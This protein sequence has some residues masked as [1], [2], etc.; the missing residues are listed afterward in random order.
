MQFEPPSDVSDLDILTVIVSIVQCG[1]AFPPAAEGHQERTPGVLPRRNLP[2]LL[3]SEAWPGENGSWPHQQTLREDWP[4]PSI[5]QVQQTS[6]RKLSEPRLETAGLTTAS[7]RGKARQWIDHE[8]HKN[9]K[10]GRRP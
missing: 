2:V 6:K 5:S 1:E 7:G 3:A 9:P 4:V 10:G 8:L